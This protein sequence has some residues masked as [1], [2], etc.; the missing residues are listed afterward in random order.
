MKTII[1][2]TI[3]GAAIC[4]LAG[5]E[6]TGLSPRE[7]AGASYPN[8]VFSLQTSDTNRPEIIVAP[9][10]L[11]VAQVGEDAPPE[12][13]L[14][15]FASQKTLI[16]SVA[17]LPLP[18]DVE[19]PYSFN[20][21]YAQK[22]DYATRVKTICNLAR[23]SGADYVFLYGGNED[24]WQE[25][26]DASFLDLTIIAGT[27]IP[28]ATIHVEGKGAGVLVS[29][30]NCRPIFFV[31]SDTKESISSPDFLVS[32]KTIALRTKVRD[33]LI[34]KLSDKLLARLADSIATTKAANQ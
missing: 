27:L 23:A 34:D 11:A 16:S 28:D 1:K 20:R 4:L 9:I 10:R 21:A 18:A 26:N 14:D 31:S 6:T 30:S 32:G 33:E 24:A 12:A 29:T 15:K 2:L 22:A 13:M 5:C 8:Y 25:N 17:G 3:A 7:A 19:N